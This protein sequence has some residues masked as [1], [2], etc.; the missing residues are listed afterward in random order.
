MS[1]VYLPVVTEFQPSSA[2]VYSLNIHKQ[3]IKDIK[4]LG[5]KGGFATLSQFYTFSDGHSK[6][7]VFQFINDHLFLLNT[8]LE[9]PRHILSIFGRD[10]LLDLELNRDYEEDFE[11]L[12]ITIRTNLSPADSLNLLDRLD[13]EW[14][15]DID[16]DISNI[17][18]I[19]VRPT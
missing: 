11:G 18:E 19:M 8:L 5:G 3:L 15:L 14:W 2:Y 10:V 12:F 6:D 16:D 1:S 9:A 13:M 4:T 7:E 17:L